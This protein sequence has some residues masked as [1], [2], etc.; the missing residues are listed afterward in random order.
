MLSGFRQLAF[1]QKQTTQIEMGINVGR[2][3]LQ[4]LSIFRDCLFWLSMSFQER[5]IAI[6]RLRRLGARRIA[7]SHSSRLVLATQL[8]QKI[9]VA[10]MIF[11]VL[12]LDA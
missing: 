9:G 2:I 4:S 12:R 6:V 10:G 1:F 11:S 8:V 5:T 7:V 3:Q